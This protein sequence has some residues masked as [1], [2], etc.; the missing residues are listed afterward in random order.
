MTI[1]RVQ[2]STSV[3]FYPKLILHKFVLH[4][5]L[6]LFSHTNLFLDQKGLNSIFMVDFELVALLPECGHLLHSSSFN[7]DLEPCMPTCVGTM[8][9]GDPQPR[10]CL[11]R[12]DAT[13]RQAPPPARTC[14]FPRAVRSA[15]PCHAAG[16]LQEHCTNGD[17]HARNIWW[18][19]LPWHGTRQQRVTGTVAQVSPLLLICL[20][21]GLLLPD[22]TVRDRPCGDAQDQTTPTAPSD[23]RV[24]SRLPTQ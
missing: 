11:Q 5:S 14:F 23:Q 18:G 2:E 7:S 12:L 20:R 8:P 4:L 13:G 6:L 24:A 21:H 3:H 22:P 10:V 16:A 15:G 1:W 17:S 19:A 9:Q